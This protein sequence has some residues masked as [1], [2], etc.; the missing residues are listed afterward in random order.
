M[1]ISPTRAI[2]ECGRSR[3][4]VIIT[5][6]AGTPGATSPGDGGQATLAN[7]HPSALALDTGGNLYISDNASIRKVTPDGI[8]ST[9][10]TGIYTGSLAVDPGG[11]LYFSSGSA[12]YKLSPGSSTPV[13]IAGDPQ[14][15]GYSGDGGPALKALFRG[16]LHVT[17]GSGGQIF[18]GDEGNSRVRRIT[19]DGTVTTI[20]GNGLYGYVGENAPA[21][22][23]PLS[24]FHTRAKPNG[25]SVHR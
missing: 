8:I 10:I 21:L 6:I 12:I 7:I 2:S 20:A 17:L 19:G 25:G 11:T 23:S 22:A 1:S 18:V 13:L 14:T 24:P 15:G 5:T 9:V 4:Q 3:P 16:P